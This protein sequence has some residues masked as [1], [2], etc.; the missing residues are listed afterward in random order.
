MSNLPVQQS[1]SA[2]TV[3]ENMVSSVS[4]SGYAMIEPTLDALNCSI[5]ITKFLYSRIEKFF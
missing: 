4:F 1:N 3:I 5:F 2:L